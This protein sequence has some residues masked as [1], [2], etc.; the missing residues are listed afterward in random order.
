MG[1]AKES[2]EGSPKWG[3]RKATHRGFLNDDKRE[4]AFARFTSLKT[5]PSRTQN[6]IDLASEEQKK[7]R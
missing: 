5:G 6:N 7:Y 2:N 3:K 4:L 1:C